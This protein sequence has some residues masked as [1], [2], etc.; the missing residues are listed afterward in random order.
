MSECTIKLSRSSSQEIDNSYFFLEDYLE[1]PNILNAKDLTDQIFNENKEFIKSYDY[2][3]YK[4]SW[5]WYDN[6]FQSALDYLSIKTLVDEI[7]AVN[8]KKIILVG[9]PNKYA[10]VLKLYFFRLE[11]QFP[12]KNNYL[13]DFQ[14]FLFN[15]IMLFFTS[16][17]I[18]FFY[19]RKGFNIATRTEDFI[20][21][22]TKSDFRLNHLYEKYEENNIK[23]VEFIRNTS[24]KAFFINIY[25]RKRF[26]IYYTSIIYFI[27]L[28]SRRKNTIKIPLNFFQSILYSHTDNNIALIKSTPIFEIILKILK[29]KKFVLI[30]FSSR[31]AHL[32][33]A[34]KSLK[35]PIIGIMH[36]LSQKE[37]AVHE[38]ITP[39]NEEKKIGCDIYGLWSPY[40]LEY[41]K[42]Y[43]KITSSDCFE[44]SGMLRPLKEFDSKPIFQRISIN[45]IKIL[46]ICEPL[47]SALEIIPYLRCLLKHNDVELAIKVRP[48]ISDSYY[49]ELK[50]ELPDIKKFKTFDGKIEDIANEFD[51]FLGS[52]ST[53][54]IEASLFGKISI[55]VSTKK[56]GDYFNIDSLI[57]GESLLNDSP[58]KLY[59]NT[60]NRI[61]NENSLK[62]IIKTRDRFFGE[63]L[64]GAQWIIDQIT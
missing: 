56:F 9:I 26:A 62:T 47:I 12:K 13:K 33:I 59:D 4:I 25:K 38:F 11:I 42:K 51:V 39:F 53:A 6:I 40:Y 45:K 8:P 23:Y 41:F 54:V 22:N 49:K 28:I 16:I 63:N 1:Q 57:P 43:S 32:A 60:I 21:K 31:T 34:A 20:Y 19:F 48:M 24:T 5:S 61:N 29:I 35:I 36:G 46:L 15:L 7:E 44:Y 30:T 50:L 27:N 2:E 17:S 14:E 18:A 10:R 37:Y 64:D 55:L 58:E 52:Y 3:G